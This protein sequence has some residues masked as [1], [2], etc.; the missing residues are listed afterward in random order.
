MDHSTMQ[1]GTD[2]MTILLYIG[3]AILVLA[4]IGYVLAAKVTKIIRPG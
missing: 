4:I 3:L 1:Q 2:L